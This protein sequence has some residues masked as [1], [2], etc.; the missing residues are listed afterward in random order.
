M[1][2]QDIIPDKRRLIGLVEQAS[3]G[4]LCLPNFQRDF[5]WTRD[6]VTDMLRSVLRRYY[7]GSLLLLRCDPNRPPFEPQVLRGTPIADRDARPDL[8]VLDGQQRLTSLLYAPTA[9]N[10]SLKDSKKR[11]YFFVD[12]Q[13]LVT[14]PDNEAIVFDRGEGELDGLDKPEEQYRRRVLPCTQLLSTERFMKWRDGLDDWLRDN[15]AAGHKKFRGGDRDA[16]S[17]AVSAFQCFEVPLVELPK[18]DEDD[19]H[20]IGRVCAIFEKLNSTGVELSVYDLLTARLYRHGIRVHKLW[21]EACRENERLRK[22]SAGKAENH[23]LGVLVL[24]TLALRR[25]LD[26]KPAMLIDLKPEGFA[27]D[28]KR[29]AAAME[30][31]LELVELVDE[32]GFGVFK[33]KW[34]PGMGPV[35]VLAALRAHIEDEGLGERER[36]DLRRWY[37]CNVFLERFSSGVESK[38]RKDYVEMLAYWKDRKAAPGVFAEA[39]ARIGAKGYSIRTS[40]SHSSAIYSG[41]FCLLAIRGA[42]DWALA[43]S[44]KL[45]KLQDHHIFPKAY[46]KGNDIKERAKVNSVVNRTLISGRTN[47]KIKKKAPAEYLASSDIIAPKK[48]EAVVAAHFI[49][50]DGVAAMRRAKAKSSPGDVAAAYEEFLEA[51]EQAIV[52][53]IRK[54]C[55]VRAE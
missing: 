52:A 35:P 27:E 3:E 18:V 43:E 33:E 21:H 39:Q 42:Q 29:A 47:G 40:A 24:R 34:L 4:K 1:K 9:P 16:W 51:R 32:D 44:I 11:R 17:A 55:G 19:P 46:L 53:E 25:G 36:S 38:S 28:W 22:W 2:S 15:D 48:G 14:D 13:L 54:V 20:S 23:K 6:G 10:L 37:W 26:P 8:L 12:L 49:D 30:R 5:V 45:Q 7:I 31:A 41:V 50:D